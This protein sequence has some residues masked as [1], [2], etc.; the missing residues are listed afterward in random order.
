MSINLTPRECRFSECTS[1]TQQLINQGFTIIRFNEV[2]VE[3]Q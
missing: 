2:N 3:R 1:N